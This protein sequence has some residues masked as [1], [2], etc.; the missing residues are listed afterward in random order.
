MTL[1]LQ[2]VYPTAGNTTFDLDYYL[3]THMALVAQHI[4]EHLS[5][6]MITRGLHGGPNTPAPYHVIATLT[7]ADKAALKAAMA[8]IDPVA[9]DIPNFYSGAPQMLFGE[10]I[11]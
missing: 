3:A 2:V 10:V 1:S 6:T 8:K 11:G 4:G 9:A 7:F 5:G